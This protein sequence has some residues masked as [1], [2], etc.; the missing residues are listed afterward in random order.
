MPSQIHSIKNSDEKCTVWNCDTN[1]ACIS[2]L[3]SLPGDILCDPSFF[4]C[5][6][7]VRGY[8]REGDGVVCVCVCGMC[9]LLSGWQVDIME[10]ELDTSSEDFFNLTD[11]VNSRLVYQLLENVSY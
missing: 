8:G 6:V 2:W 5:F 3:G 9:E 11:G 1:K 7:A 10:E 4:V